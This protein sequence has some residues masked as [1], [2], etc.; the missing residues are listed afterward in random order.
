MTKKCIIC[1]KKAEYQIKDS[2]DF[3]CQECAEENFADLTLLVKV[4]EEAER[5]KE[6]LKEKMGDLEQDEEELDKY[7]QDDPARNN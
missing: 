2:A 5:L 4:K 1:G 6:Y 7:I 3:Y